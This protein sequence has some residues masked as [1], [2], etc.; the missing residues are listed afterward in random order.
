MTH[1]PRRTEPLAPE[2]RAEL[3]RLLS[4]GSRR[5]L[6]RAWGV[7]PGV[8]RRAAAGEGVTP[9]ARRFLAERVSGVRAAA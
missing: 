2:H 4:Q 5:A 7:S 9:M 1:R 8:L 3:V 6:A